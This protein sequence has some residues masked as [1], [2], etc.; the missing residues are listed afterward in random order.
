MAEINLISALGFPSVEPFIAVLALVI[1]VVGIIVVIVALKPVLDLFPYGY[2]NARIRARLGRLFD[3]KQYSEMIE[4]DNEEEVTNYLRGF[5]EYAKYLETYPVEKALDSQ[6]AESYQTLYTVAPKSIKPVFK[7]L[8]MKWDIRNIKTIIIATEMN[9]TRDQTT[10]LLI[11][12]GANYDIIEKLIESNEITDIVAGLEGTPYAQALEDALTEYSEKQMVL[13]LESAL[14]KF[15][16]TELLRTS[17]TP[18]EENTRIMHSYVGSMVDIANL[19]LILRAKADGLKYDSIS[20]YIMEGGYQI[21]DW[22][23]KD[24]MESEDAEGVISGIEGT[25]YSPAL[26]DAITEYNKTGSV[27]VFEAALDTYLVTKATNLSRKKP[28]GIGPLVAFVNR[29]EREIKN[30]KIIIRGKRE[31][32]VSNTQIKEMLI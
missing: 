23:L 16:L 8:N 4:A 24:L 21:R 12:F 11:P 5:P 14:D 20:P 9:L 28:F 25:E 13:P 17:A 7:A 31:E 6:L 15:Y 27:A 3:D 10:E 1:C 22:K 2:P 30:L 18:D 32:N 19:T 29:K 26:S